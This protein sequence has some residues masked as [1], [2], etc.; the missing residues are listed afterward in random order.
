MHLKQELTLFLVLLLVFFL[1]KP[2]GKYLFKVLSPNEKT[3]LDP[4][5]KP[6]EK[7]TYKYLGIDVSRGQSWKEYFGSM[8]CFSFL[9]FLFSFLLLSAQKLLPLNPQSFEGLS[10]SL[11]FNATCSYL[12]NT[13]WQSFKPESTLSYFSYLFPLSLQ[14]FLSP[15]I[16]I[17]VLA[18]LARSL[19]RSQKKVLGNFWV[20]I[21]RIVYYFLL[22]LALFFSILFIALGTPQN[23]SPYKEV[24]TLETGAVQNLVQGP[25]A[26]VS[27]IKL[28]GTNGANYT[29]VG[30]AHPYENPSSLSNILQLIALLLIPAAQTYYFGKEVNHQKHGWTIF[31]VMVF[32][33]IASSIFCQLSEMR[34]DPHIASL[35]IDERVGNIEG[36]EQR[37][38]VFDSTLFSTA[39]T[40]ASNG[41]TNSSLDS[42]TPFGGMVPLINMLL[43]QV[44]FGGA[45]AGMYNMVIYVL[46]ALF[47]SGLIVG[48]V[49]DYLGKKI[50]GKEVK[51]AM[52]SLLI[53]LVFVL[54]GTAWATNAKWG[55]QSITAPTAHGFT[56]I[57]YAFTST[58]ANNGSA[59]SALNSNL[60]AWNVILGFVMLLGRYLL[61]F[62]IMALGGSFVIKSKQSLI[63]KE[64]VL[65]ISGWFFASLLIGI[66]IIVGLMSFAPALIMG[67]VIEQF[68]P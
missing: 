58:A 19:S 49:P 65:P 53:F 33:F 5:L 56:E 10:G 62:C 42:Y 9:I 1:T 37:F 50:E 26:S 40:A 21:V 48:K 27:A 4:I 17:S 3:W 41:T 61:I 32:F 44:V 47:L 67:P 63:T 64:S 45:G 55:L 24:Q 39:T 52:Y 57:L 28:L 46:I 54:G 60:P 14:N 13:C 68:S 51:L 20:D 36:K 2:V 25:I 35:N 8:L 22:P 29:N 38:G 66:I 11:N 15:A 12:T 16:G 34:Y 43:G 23:V 30:S 18:V 59:F 31:G 6:L 7:T